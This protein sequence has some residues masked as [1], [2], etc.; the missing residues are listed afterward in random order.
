MQIKKWWNE[1]M[2]LGFLYTL[3]VLSVKNSVVGY[4]LSMF[5]DDIKYMCKSDI[6]PVVSF[7]SEG[8]IFFF[9]INQTEH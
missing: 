6:W 5:C 3:T 8:L 1:L 9:H 2:K 7:A 4:Q